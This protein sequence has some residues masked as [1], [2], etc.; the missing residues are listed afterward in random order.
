ME[1]LG[2]LVVVLAI[3][4]IAGVAWLHFGQHTRVELSRPGNTLAPSTLPPEL[5]TAGN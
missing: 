2:F 4:A 3:A 1:L 5:E